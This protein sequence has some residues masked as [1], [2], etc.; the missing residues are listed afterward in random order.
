MLKRIVDRTE[1]IISLYMCVMTWRRIA[2]CRHTLQTQNPPG[3][4]NNGRLPQRLVQRL[5]PGSA[6]TDRQ[7]VE[8]LALVV[9]RRAIPERV[10]ERDD[11]NANA[12]RNLLCG[13]AIGNNPR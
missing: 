3:G 4:V 9:N 11:S 1:S 8:Y 5:P 7:H 13:S 10:V 2:A 6:G 12:L